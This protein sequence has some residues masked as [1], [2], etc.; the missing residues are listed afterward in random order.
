MH[1]AIPIAI[2]LCAFGQALLP[3]DAVTLSGVVIDQETGRAIRSALVRAV[4][5]GRQIGPA[6]LTNETGEFSLVVPAG[7]IEAVAAKHGFVRPPWRPGQ[8]AHTIVASA[9]EHVSV[10]RLPLRRGGVIAGTIIT[11]RGRELPGAAVT[12]L[13]CAGLEPCDAGNAAAI[14]SN[15]TDER[16]RYRFYGLPPGTYYLVADYRLDSGSSRP[17]EFPSLDANRQA[18]APVTSVPTFYPGTTR[19]AE[20]AAVTLEAGEERQ[21]VDFAAQ[22]GTASTVSGTLAGRRDGS[23]PVR[24]SVFPYERGP[25]RSGPSSLEVKDP[26]VTA[27][28]PPG[29]YRLAARAGQDAWAEVVVSVDGRNIENLQLELAPTVR[30]GGRIVLDGA[31]PAAMRDLSGVQITFRRAD[32]PV[33]VSTLDVVSTT[34]A[35]SG[36]FMATGLIP[37]RY[38]VTCM[39][40]PPLK[41][42]LWVKSIVSGGLDVTE[43]PVE[44]ASMA[45]DLTILMTS[46]LAELAGQVRDERGRPVHEYTVL[47]FPTDRSKWST[48]SRRIVVAA[49]SA[50]GGFVIR[51]LPAGEYSLGLIGTNDP[52]LVDRP[53]L[54]ALSSLAIRTTVAAGEARRIDLQIKR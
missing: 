4:V 6:V 37:G 1:R 11:I 49:P 42:P 44:I 9:G 23:T 25:A 15:T 13:R 36:D 51:N 14:Q 28:L 48:G 39:P 10:I 17:I 12:L 16:G 41:E 34:S 30:A 7:R 45:T 8:P 54:E 22:L 46:R 33:V 20:A 3:Q 29:K 52:D 38:T 43:S 50:D 21:G 40:I 18:V 2:L 24:L 27:P 31:A 5:D 32:V 53:L 47:A 35:P 26:F 19:T